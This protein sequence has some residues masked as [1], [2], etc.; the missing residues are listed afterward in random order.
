MSVA[1][2]SDFASYY[3]ELASYAPSYEDRIKSLM[4]DEVCERKRI[5]GAEYAEF[6]DALHIRGVWMTEKRAAMKGYLPKL[7]PPEL[8]I[9]KREREIWF[10]ALQP[11]PVPPPTNRI[12]YAYPF[13]KV[14]KLCK[15]EMEMRAWLEGVEGKR[16]GHIVAMAEQGM[17]V[18]TCLN[19]C[20]MKE[21]RTR[22]RLEK[23][24]A[25]IFATIRKSF[26]KKVPADYYRAKAIER[27]GEQALSILPRRPHHIPAIT[28]EETKSSREDAP[29]RASETT[30]PMPKLRRY[31]KTP[32]MD[33]L[34][35]VEPPKPQRSPRSNY[36]LPGLSAATATAA[37]AGPSPPSS[38]RSFPNA[39][40]LSS[41]RRLK[42]MPLPMPSTTSDYY[43]TNNNDERTPS[44]D[45]VP[46][47]WKAL[48][49][50]RSRVLPPLPHP[51]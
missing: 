41:D 49:P 14:R 3:R 1:R 47:T 36:T 28:P 51:A 38:S 32:C 2:Y 12:M 8:A 23:D 6:Q 7:T 39:Q 17:Y 16:R 20:A 42:P 30:P 44:R 25:A 24:E 40:N 22:V 5:A 43:T 18:M 26:F 27:H 46:I 4:R 13:A 11:R 10:P 29:S 48:P 37:G 21:E 15:E 45:A 33:A 35:Q 34:A 31:N 9:W 19:D 50:P